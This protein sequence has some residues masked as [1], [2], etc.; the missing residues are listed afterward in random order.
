MTP[1]KKSFEISFIV[2]GD[3]ESR[4]DHRTRSAG[5]SAID[6]YATR[7]GSAVTFVIRADPFVES[8][9]SAIC[10]PPDQITAY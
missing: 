6:L 8:F 1:N 2:L 3:F 4:D 9:K 7:A 5:S 10:C